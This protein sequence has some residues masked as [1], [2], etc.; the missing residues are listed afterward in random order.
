MTGILTFH[1]LGELNQ[2]P[3]RPHPDNGCAHTA[4]STKLGD[5]VITSAADGHCRG[6]SFNTYAI[7]TNFKQFLELKASLYTVEQLMLTLLTLLLAVAIKSNV[8]DDWAPPPE[9]KK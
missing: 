2:Q 7:V 5:L 9:V 1:L 3:S 4:L 8:K 6:A